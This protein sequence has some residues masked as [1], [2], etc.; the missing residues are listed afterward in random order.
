MATS[1]PGG[2]GGRRPPA[3][4]TSSQSC[5]S[6]GIVGRRRPAPARRGETPRRG[7]RD[8]ESR[9]ASGAATVRAQ[10]SARCA[11]TPPP[12]TAAIAPTDQ[13][14]ITRPPAGG[15][16]AAGRPRRRAALR[17]IAVD[18]ATATSAAAANRSA[19][20]SPD[21]DRRRSRQ[22]ARAPPDSRRDSRAARA[23]GPRPGSPSVLPP[24]RPA[25]GEHLVERRRRARRC[26]RGR[27]TASPRICSGAM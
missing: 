12:A 8:S 10:R 9:C 6:C 21:S 4:D 7:R 2:L 15:A 20:A 23:S 22:R 14:P 16:S 3:T 27:S 18:G 26:R 24:E 5:C 13:Q 11:V 1:A 17:M 25:A 19:G